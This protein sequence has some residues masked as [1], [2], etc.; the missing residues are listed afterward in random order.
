MLDIRF[1]AACVLSNFTLVI[2]KHGWFL[3]SQET[4]GSVWPHIWRLVCY[5][6]A[7]SFLIV[8]NYIRSENV[9]R[10][11]KPSVLPR[12]SW[13]DQKLEQQPSSFIIRFY[14]ITDK[15]DNGKSRHIGWHIRLHFCH[16]SK[17]WFWNKKA[18]I[19][20][21]VLKLYTCFPNIQVILLKYDCDN[22]IHSYIRTTA[23]TFFQ[24]MSWYLLVLT[25]SI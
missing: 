3:T 21:T 22:I 5:Q 17:N 24:C 8:M 19:L 23:P 20:V 12:K 13:L 4:Y 7:A 6:A 25:I 14:I 18:Q 15:S 9:S 11:T 2:P 10:P 1:L 16:F